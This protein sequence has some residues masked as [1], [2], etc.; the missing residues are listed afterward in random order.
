[1]STSHQVISTRARSAAVRRARRTPVLAAVGILLGSCAGVVAG[2]GGTAQASSATSSSGTEYYL[3]LGDSLAAGAGS[4]DGKGYVADIY[5]KE[6]NRISGLVLENLACSGATTTSMIK[7]PGCAYAT[8]TQLGDAEAFLEAHRGEVAFITIDIGANDVVP[9]IDGSAVNP[10]CVSA[11]MNTVGTNLPHILSGLTSAGGSVPIVGMSYYDPFLADWLTGASGESL[12]E[13]TESV[14]AQL[15]TAL[16][17]Y[18]GSALTAGVENAFKTS[19][20]HPGGHYDGKA[21]PVNVGRIC[22]WTLMCTEENIHANDIGHAHIA[23]AFEKILGPLLD[24]VRRLPHTPP[25]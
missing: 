23:V 18:Y 17:G 25:V 11:A 9:C 6:Q 15:D 5:A 12:A 10:A 20:F 3:A 24:S 22:A 14:A 13:Q 19:D 2:A 16:A 1:M 21:V 8:G 4:P 7:G